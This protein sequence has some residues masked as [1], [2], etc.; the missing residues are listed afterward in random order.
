MAP[1]ILRLGKWTY[2]T[3]SRVHEDIQTPLVIWPQPRV[4]HYTAR[5]P[6]ADV[7]SK[8]GAI[9]ELP[10]P[11][12]CSWISWLNLCHTHLPQWSR[13]ILRLVPKGH[14]YGHRTMKRLFAVKMI[15]ST[16]I[17]APFNPALPT[18]LQTNASC[19]NR[20][21]YALLQDHSS[22]HLHDSDSLIKAWNKTSSVSRRLQRAPYLID[23]F[24]NN[25]REREREFYTWEN[26][27]SNKLIPDHV[28][29]T[30]WRKNIR[31]QLFSTNGDHCQHL[32]KIVLVTNQVVRVGYD[33]TW[34]GQRKYKFCFAGLIDFL[35]REFPLG[36]THA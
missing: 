9:R 12:N 25:E 23:A 36:E 35:M 30:Q 24:Y 21:G 33:K 26:Q 29:F 19:L 28:S 31:E 32:P 27:I 13:F 10:I 1:A 14:S 5:F 6:R 34:W 20:V 8:V 7:C 22:G 11:T 15:S 2:P 3:W 18:I 17:L 4:G 16:P